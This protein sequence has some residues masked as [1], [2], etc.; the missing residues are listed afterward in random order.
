[1]VSIIRAD[2]FPLGE[3][4]HE[5]ECGEEGKVAP[6]KEYNDFIKNYLMCLMR[7]ILSICAGPESEAS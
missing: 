6:T 3:I 1:M 2:F 7:V 4:T 5:Q